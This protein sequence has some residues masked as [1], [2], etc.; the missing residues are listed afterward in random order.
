MMGDTLR[1]GHSGM[2]RSGPVAGLAFALAAL[3]APAVHAQAPLGGFTTNYGSN[4]N[5]PIDI[6][7]DLLEVDDKK[8]LATF[9][10]NVSATQGDFNMKSKELQVSYTAGGAQAGGAQGG[11]KKEAGAAQGGPLPGGGGADITHI[12]AKGDVILTTKESQQAKSDWAIFDVKKQLVT[13]GGNVRLS[14]GK[15]NVIQ[16]DKVVIDL[17]TGLSTVENTGQIKAVFT[18]TPKEKPKDAGKEGN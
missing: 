5:K 4:A 3:A 2:W 14:R 9:K 16:G 11:G 12:D 10:G 6:A 18:P 7:A 8:K 17:A 13:L 1:R 15:D